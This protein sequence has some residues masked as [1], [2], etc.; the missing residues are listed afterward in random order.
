[1]KLLSKFIVTA[2]GLTSIVNAAPTSSS[3]A[4]EAQKLF[5]LNLVSV[6]NN[7]LTFTM[8]QLS[9]LM[10]LLKVILW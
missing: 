2:L 3:S 6:S 4:E 7:F 9:M 10:L 8:I 5:L 1:M